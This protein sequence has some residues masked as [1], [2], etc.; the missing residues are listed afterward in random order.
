MDRV[1]VNAFAKVVML[2]CE[3]G[4]FAFR[5]DLNRR[6]AL[7]TTAVL[8]LNATPA[9]SRMR[10]TAVPIFII[11]WTK[12]LL[13]IFFVTAYPTLSS[14]AMALSAKSLICSPAFSSCDTSR[15]GHPPGAPPVAPP[16]A[17]AFAAAPLTFFVLFIDRRGPSAF[18]MA[19]NRSSV[20][21][22]H[23]SASPS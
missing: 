16:V 4:S 3:F 20:A 17:A 2:A 1:F 8:A 14:A 18:K 21:G 7:S 13:R 12:G 15:E 9:A 19:L 6:W 10:G 22:A 5:S 11:I 23:E